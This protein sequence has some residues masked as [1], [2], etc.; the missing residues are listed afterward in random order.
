MG[1][2]LHW[3][4]CDKVLGKMKDKCYG[5]D[6]RPARLRPSGRLTV[7]EEITMASMNDETDR[8]R[9]REIWNLPG[10]YVRMESNRGKKCT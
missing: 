7:F 8:P 5:A 2:L 9:Q 4:V 10:S 6:E 3:D 1:L